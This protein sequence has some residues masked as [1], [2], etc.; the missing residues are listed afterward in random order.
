MVQKALEASKQLEEE[1][2]SVI[3]I[4]MSTIKPID[5]EIIIKAAKETKGIVTAEEHSIIGG[6][7]DT[8][9]SVVCD[10]VPTIVKKIGI[11]DVF[12]QSGTPDELLEKYGLTTSNIVNTV[13]SIIK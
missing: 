3:V 10:S 4:N 1:G 7:G 12:G 6:L 2:I 13:K 5:R 11:N 9:A 8:V